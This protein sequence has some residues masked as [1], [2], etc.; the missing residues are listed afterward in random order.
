MGVHLSHYSLGASIFNYVVL[1]PVLLP[2]I[3][4]IGNL[5]I[6]LPSSS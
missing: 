6:G 3:G 5:H 1:M 2:K 4:V